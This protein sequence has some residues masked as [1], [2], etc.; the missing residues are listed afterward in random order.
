VNAS[1]TKYM[2]I[3]LDQNAEQSEYV[4]ND[5]SGF[6]MVDYFKCLGKTS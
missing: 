2:F 1:N 5:D 4:K 3:S 6:K